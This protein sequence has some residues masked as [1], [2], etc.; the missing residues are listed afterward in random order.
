MRHELKC[1]RKSSI[2]RTVVLFLFGA[3]LVCFV[4]SADVGEVV[5]TSIN[6]ISTDSN[7]NSKSKL[8]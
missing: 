3:L 8:F 5:K 1:D 7:G 4:Y 6:F 2:M